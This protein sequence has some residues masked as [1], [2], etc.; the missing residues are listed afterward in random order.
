[1]PT[2]DELFAAVDALL[3]GEPELPSPAERARLRE[4]AG[5]TQGRLA[6]VL[7]TST[8]TVRN[9]E[10]GRSEPRPPRR[11]AY[12]RLLDGWAAKY[13]E[14]ADT[15]P[16][17]LP[18]PETFASP[19]TPAA[20]EAQPQEQAS[21]AAA[22]AV[23]TAAESAQPRPAAVPAPA[24]ASRTARPSS[25]SRRPGVKKAAPAGTPTSGGA[26][27]H[28][29]LLVIDAGT[30]RNVTG[31]G[32]GG[33]LLDVPAKSLPALV[34][35]TLAEAR[36]GTEKLHGSGKD[37]DPL[38]VLTPA[39]CERYGLPVELSEGERLAGRIPENHTVV[40]QLD[41]ADWQLTKR[42]LGPWARIYRPAQGRRRQ[43][44][45]LCI[46]SWHALDDRAW[47]HAARLEPAE[48][49]RVLGVY[50][51]RVMTPV[52]STAVTGLE[53][54]TALN[55][56]TRASEPDENGKRHPEHRPGSLGVQPMDPAP[57]EATDGHPVLADL[58]RFH[59]R[60]PD[61]KLFEEAYDW[62]RELTDEECMRRHL[63]GIDV[64]L[65]FG[66]AANGAVVGL[67]TPPEHVTHPTFDPTLPGAWLVDLSHID[68]SRVLVGKQWRQLQGDLL[69][70]PFTPTGERPTGPAWYATPTVA[71]AVELGYDVAPL[72]A[73]VRREKGKPL[74]GWYKRLRDAY[75]HTMGDLD[76]GEKLPPA[77]FLA[78]MDGYKQRD[79]ELA[80]VLN[81]IKMTTKGGIGKLREKAR[82]GGWRP[83][84]AWPALA[85]PTWR[86][87]IR[88]AVISRA[89][90]NMHR[91]MLHLAAATGRYPVAILSD[92]AVYAADGPSPLDVLPYDADGKTVPGSFRLGVSPG[93]VKHEGTQTVLWGAAVHEQ[94]DGDGKVANL[95]RYIKT[96]EITA[97]DTGE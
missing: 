43:C 22:A 21:G 76:V 72:E 59:V 64:N 78:A 85:R 54:M 62:A 30:D 2:E 87:D 49:A 41:R 95:A 44:V 42:G 93:M 68:L 14:P 15:K 38:L 11:Q 79:P 32:V 81:A 34:E 66:A 20:E 47:G 83:G 52:G 8:Q 71:Y 12:Q 33:L 55:P 7:Q 97:K 25:T 39:A 63:V 3:E 86:P 53:L 9:W 26:Y 67:S 70:S 45:Q 73:W 57:C 88:A 90:I 27:A 65:A 51:T 6:Q 61:E 23:V 29:P 37:A 48:L 46:P 24:A 50:A 1:M 91:K 17:A 10:A 56:P 40:K 74:D 36:L 58:P 60:G 84:Q 80:I 69:P 18:V 92:C 16:E 82:G 75:V 35:W 94:L 5:V 89:R 31:Y 96:G 19:A 13:T 28:G 77:E 4:A